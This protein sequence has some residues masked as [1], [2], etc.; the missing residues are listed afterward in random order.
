M[1]NHTFLIGLHYHRIKINS[2]NM[3]KLLHKART[4]ITIKQK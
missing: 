1:P 4:A 2:E 3:M